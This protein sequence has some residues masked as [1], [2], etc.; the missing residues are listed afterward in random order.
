MYPT[1][2]FASRLPKMFRFSEV[3]REKTCKFVSGRCSKIGTFLDTGRRCARR[4]FLRGH[5]FSECPLKSPSFGT[6]LGDQ[7]KYIT[8][9]PITE[10]YTFL[11]INA[12]QN[13]LRFSTAGR[14]FYFLS[15]WQQLINTAWRRRELRRRSSADSAS[16]HPSRCGQRK[17]ACRRTRGPSS[18]WEAGW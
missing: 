4:G 12:H 8:T 1:R 14:P 2:R 18:F 17:S 15:S 9:P 10:N 3:Y 16:P 5:A 6:F 13:A 7:E 11:H